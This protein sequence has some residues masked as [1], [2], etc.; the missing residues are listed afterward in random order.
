MPMRSA[1]IAASLAAIALVSSPAAARESEDERALGEMADTLSDPGAQMAFAAMLAGMSE[2]LLDLRIEPMVRAAES[3]PGARP[4]RDLPPD[5]RLRD[6]AGPEAER[7]PSAIA[8]ET[9]RMMG[10]MAGMA[11]GFEGMIPELRRMAER[12]KQAIP[13]RD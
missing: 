3:M 6:V 11:R 8:R 7:M 9:P 1:F 4:M 12:M 10:A 13:R 2:A 5:A